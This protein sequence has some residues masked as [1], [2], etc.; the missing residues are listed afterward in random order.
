MCEGRDRKVR[1]PGV[2]SL[3]STAAQVL[4]LTSKE[5]I[6]RV[7]APL[8]VSSRKRN[9]H[10]A[11]PYPSSLIAFAAFDRELSGGGESRSTSVPLSSASV[12]LPHR[13][14]TQHSSTTGSSEALLLEC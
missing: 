9:R 4:Q 11:K 10:F 6:D 2:L 3:T 12:V 14:R 1:A 13:L 5:G 7:T 8:L